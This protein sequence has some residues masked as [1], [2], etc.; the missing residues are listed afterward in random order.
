MFKTPSTWTQWPLLKHVQ[1]RF[2]SF[3]PEVSGFVRA[4]DA[5]LQKV[6]CPLQTLELV[7]VKED[8]VYC[9]TR[10]SSTWS[11]CVHHVVF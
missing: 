5:V 1:F 10:S 9:Y 2:A 8:K 11:L 3:T 4:L 7:V 6:Q